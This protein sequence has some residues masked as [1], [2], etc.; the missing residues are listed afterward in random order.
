MIDFNSIPLSSGIIFEDYWRREPIPSDE[1]QQANEL[2]E[3]LAEYVNSHSDNRRMGLIKKIVFRHRDTNTDE[4]VT[5]QW[6]FTNGKEV[7]ADIYCIFGFQFR[8]GTQNSKLYRSHSDLDH[9]NVGSGGYTDWEYE[10][11]RI[12]VFYNRLCIPIKGNILH[13]NPTHAGCLIAGQLSGTNPNSAYRH[14]GN[15]ATSAEGDE[16]FMKF[17][18][19]TQIKRNKAIAQIVCK[20][21]DDELSPNNFTSNYTLEKI[22]KAKSELDNALSEGKEFCAKDKMKSSYGYYTHEEVDKLKELNALSDYY[23]VYSI[24]KV[25]EKLEDLKPPVVE[26]D[27]VVC[28][29]GSA[30]SGILDQVGRLSHFTKYKL[31]DFDIIERKNL[32]NQWYTRDEIGDYKTNTSKRRLLRFSS[33]ETSNSICVDVSN[34]KWEDSYLQYTKGKYIVSGFDSIKTRLELFDFVASNNLEYNYWIDTRYE[35]QEASVWFVDLSNQEEKDYYRKRLII[36]GEV[37]EEVKEEPYWNLDNTKEI[38]EKYNILVFN[39]GKYAHKLGLF[40]YCNDFSCGST[41]CIQFWCDNL[42]RKKIKPED[43]DNPNYTPPE[44][45]TC[46]AMNLIVIYKLASTFVTVAIN[47]I[48]SG[49]SKDFTH[50][51]VTTDGTVAFRKM[52]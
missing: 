36:D 25:K 29:L 45:N 20:L 27:M 1:R 10:G 49:G 12:R 37:L 38:L 31:I 40:D 30:G 7:H 51:E 8:K 5:N 39:C 50:I 15:F 17:G 26:Y 41:N 19:M 9:D 16:P 24:S 35:G 52:R 21:S 4:T 14:R 43:F 22:K 11:Y 13:N 48:E 18:N 34:S 47:N 6:V 3:Q 42:N 32:R 23:R 44:T 46:L 2:L 33:S 28:G